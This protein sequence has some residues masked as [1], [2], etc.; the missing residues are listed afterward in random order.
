MKKIEICVKNILER[1]HKSEIK[2][3]PTP[4]LVQGN[5]NNMDEAE[6]NRIKHGYET[7]KADSEELMILLEA[8]LKKVKMLRNVL[9]KEEE[10]ISKKAFEI[11]VRRFS[12]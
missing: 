10:K 12:R 2:M 8:V 11:S 4:R 6:L 7:A 5:N 9:K 3:E 1:P